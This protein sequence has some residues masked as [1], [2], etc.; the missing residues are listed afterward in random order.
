[1][2]RGR[3]R[4][5]L[6]EQLTSLR[7]AIPPLRQ[8]PEDIPLIAEHLVRRRA[9]A[10]G[11]AAPVLDAE[12]LDALKRHGWTGNVRELDE[13]LA[14]AG[15][16]RSLIRAEDLPES[17]AGARRRP[18]GATGSSLRQAVSEL[19]VGLISQA[20]DDTNWN[21]SRAARNLGLSRLGLQKK[22]DR[23]GIDR[24]R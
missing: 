5:E 4:R 7:I 10:A 14:R 22:I 9:A 21:K 17:V 23:Y 12:A 20:L 6:A 15:A 11:A 2:R 13:E 3:F 19:E 16:G 1:V 18:E 24:R 8:R